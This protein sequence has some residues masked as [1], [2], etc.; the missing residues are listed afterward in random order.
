LR[1]DIAVVTEFAETWL[2]RTAL[3]EGETE[4]DVYERSE[5]YCGLLGRAGVAF[6]QKDAERKECEKYVTELLQFRRALERITAENDL[7]CRN[8][9]YLRD[10]DVTMA[11]LQHIAST[12]RLHFLFL[13]LQAVVADA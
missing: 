6:G 7:L 11:A 10:Y 3:F 13:D 2:R 9:E 1:R 5:A 12:V 4:A 8:D